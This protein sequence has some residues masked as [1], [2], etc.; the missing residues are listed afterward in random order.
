MVYSIWA[1][2]H[3]L[4]NLILGGSKF[5]LQLPHVFSKLKQHQVASIEL[6]KLKKDSLNMENIDQKNL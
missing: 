6:K 4:V 3:L 2:P 5:L 1:K